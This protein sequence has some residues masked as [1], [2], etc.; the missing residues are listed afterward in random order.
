[1]DVRSHYA[2]CL[3]LLRLTGRGFAVGAL[4]GVAVYLVLAQLIL[5]QVWPQSR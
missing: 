5:G 4:A 2:R 1:M 3:V